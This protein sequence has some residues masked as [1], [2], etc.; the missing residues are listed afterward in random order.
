M[1]TRASATQSC[2]CFWCRVSRM[3]GLEYKRH[4]ESVRP[5]TKAHPKPKAVKRC[6]KC[7]GVLARGVRHECT[8]T[9]RNNNSKE[10]VREF[11]DEGQRRVTSSLINSFCEEEGVDKTSGHLELNSGNKMKHITI[12]KPKPCPQISIDDMV[13]FG[14]DN[15]L[16]DAKLKTTATLIRRT[17]GKKSVEKNLKKTLPKLKTDLDDYFEYKMVDTVRKKKGKENIIESIPLVAAHDVKGFVSKA[18]ADRGLDPAETDVIVGL[19]DGGQILKVKHL[20]VCSNLNCG[21]LWP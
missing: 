14:G 15:D 16:S 5:V 18:M 19:D 10:M 2:S 17:F 9:A 11:S 20:S 4:S 12:G 7:L 3:N 8:K 13:K 1:V 6:D 21:S